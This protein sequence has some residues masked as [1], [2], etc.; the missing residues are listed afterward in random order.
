MSDPLKK[1]AEATR[2]AHESLEIFRRA[3][4]KEREG[5]GGTREEYLEVFSESVREESEAIEEFSRAVELQRQ[6]IQPDQ[7]TMNEE[8][9]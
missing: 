8:G 4:T 6:A 3:A 5:R 2:L 9:D 7:A 1:N